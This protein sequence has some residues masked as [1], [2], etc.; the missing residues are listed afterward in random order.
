MQT[1]FAEKEIITASDLQDYLRSKNA[2]VESSADRIVI[3]NPNTRI[4]RV[5]TA[6]TPYFKTLEDAVE[7]GINVLIVYGPTFYMD[8]DPETLENIVHQCFLHTPSP[9]RE[10]YM[11]ALEK[12]KKWIEEH[13]L[14]VIRS[15]DLPNSLT[16]P[17]GLS[18]KLGFRKEYIVG[19]KEY[20]NV[21]RVERIKASDLVKKIALD[22]K[23]LNQPG[24]AFYG[25]PD[26]YVST[27]G[28]GTGEYCD[29]R[30]YAELNPGLTIGIDDTIWTWL[31]TAYA[32]D[33]GSPL[34]VINQGTAEEMGMRL[35]NELLHTEIPSVEFLHISQGCD[36]EWITG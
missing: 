7:L 16:V 29:P 17:F 27:V 26:R 24:V 13:D 33:T 11:A 2:Y 3:G 21:Y 1:A 25:D 28:I 15:R 6:W 4:K 20:Y 12:K 32:E 8:E 22:L 18:E 30:S 31:Q 14:V 36:Y 34:V 10:Q 5:G 9:A 35:L 19:S 23:D